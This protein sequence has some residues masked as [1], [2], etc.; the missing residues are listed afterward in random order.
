LGVYT[1]YFTDSDT[2]SIQQVKN[3][4]LTI[5]LQASTKEDDGT[6]SFTFIFPSSADH[7]SIKVHPSE[8]LTYVKSKVDGSDYSL[9]NISKTILEYNSMINRLQEKLDA[10]DNVTWK[11]SLSEDI[12]FAEVIIE[13]DDINTIFNHLT[14]YIFGS[15]RLE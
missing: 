5:S 3:K 9:A 14:C 4:D 1:N 10:L 6:Q 15:K 7:Y 13:S 12:L 2:G 8:N 11:Y